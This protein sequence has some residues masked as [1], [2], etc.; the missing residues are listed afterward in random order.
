MRNITLV[1][2][3]FYWL[4]LAKKKLEKEMS[5]FVSINERE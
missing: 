1:V 5:K 2:W 3:G 4:C